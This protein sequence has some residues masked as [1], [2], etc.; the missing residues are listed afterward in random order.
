MIN[1]TAQ[2]LM[3]LDM[4]D[5]L[6]FLNGLDVEQTMDLVSG[7]IADFGESDITELLDIINSTE[8]IT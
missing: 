5:L 1:V 6:E 3:G 2:Q 7:L 8:F 4:L